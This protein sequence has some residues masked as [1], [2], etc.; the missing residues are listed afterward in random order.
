MLSAPEQ[1]VIHRLEKKRAEYMEWSAIRLG[2]LNTQIHSYNLIQRINEAL[3]ADQ[4]FETGVNA[5]LT[6][7]HANL[8]RLSEAHKSKQKV[9]REFKEQN[10]LS[11]DAN[12]STA[13]D[14][15]LAV[16]LMAACVIGDGL[17]NAY[18]FAQGDDNGLIGGFMQALICAGINVVLAFAFWRYGIPHI[19]RVHR[20]WKA[21]G[22]LMLLVFFVAAFLIAIATAHYREAL[23]VDA[24][25]PSAHALRTLQE[26]PFG[27]HEMSSW[28][29]VLLCLIV[30]AIASKKGYTY[31]DPYPGYSAHARAAEEAAADYEEELAGVREELDA[32]R[33]EAVASAKNSLEEGQQAVRLIE[34]AIRNKEEAR[35]KFEHVMQEAERAAPPLLMKFRE[36]NMI[37]AGPT[38]PR[39]AYFDTMPDLKVLPLPDFSVEADREVAA[40]QGALVADLVERE[41]G[42]CFK[43]NSA[44]NQQ[45]QLLMPLTAQFPSASSSR[46]EQAGAASETL[47][48]A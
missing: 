43:I 17:I 48:E 12:V 34:M 45:Y 24:S 5:L 3:A 13:S 25:E 30:A 26:T 1:A 42:I 47:K 31:D 33:N 16:L 29:L 4:T 22:G 46:I 18:F 8:D 9:L 44:L 38:R 10:R 7:R 11:R 19:L 39:P 14:K 23:L 6:D 27:L 2:T 36:A 15:V 21:F 40:R 41:R 32:K 35:I 37:A 20:G 28:G